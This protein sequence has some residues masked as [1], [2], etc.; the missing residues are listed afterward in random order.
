MR[1][2]TIIKVVSFLGTAAA[3]NMAQINFY[4]DDFCQNYMG[5]L[6]IDYNALGRTLDYVY[7]G[8]GSANVANVYQYGTRVGCAFYRTFYLAPT[9]Y[10]GTA[11]NDNPYTGQYS[12]CASTYR[13]YSNRIDQIY[14]D[15]AYTQ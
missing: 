3:Q 2:F 11:T 1:W 4:S 14:C 8:A 12:N 10:L 6:Q 9:L 7:S 5:E 13:Q 15:I